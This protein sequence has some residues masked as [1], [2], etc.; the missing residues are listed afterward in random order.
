MTV[1]MLKLTA[2]SRI[3][4]A[5]STAIKAILIKRHLTHTEGT[6]LHISSQCFFYIP[7]NLLFCFNVFCQLR[8]ND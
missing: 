7:V 6:T 1:S 4:E 3:P 5:A 2:F 8:H